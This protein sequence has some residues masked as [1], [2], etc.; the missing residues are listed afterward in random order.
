MLKVSFLKTL[1]AVLSCAF[2]WGI[3]SVIS[4]SFL[5]EGINE[6]YLVFLRLISIAVILFVYLTIARRDQL[7]KQ[8]LKEASI[9]GFFSVFLVSISFIYALQ[10]ISSG[11]VTLMISSA[12][13]FTVIWLKI[14]LKEERISSV[15]YFSVFI[16]FLGIAYL[17]LTQETG[18]ENQG[19]ILIGGSLAFLGVQCISLSTV[20]NRR[21]APK[22]KVTSWLAYQYPFVVV[23][24]TA[25]FFILG[26]EVQELN[27]SQIVRLTFLVF[28]NLGA[29]LTFTWLI[30][31]VSALQVASIDYLVPVVG[32]TSG[33][34]FLGESFNNNILVA[35]VFIF[36]SLIIN[37]YEE[38]SR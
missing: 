31:R 17:F 3:G 35:G 6:I 36:F 20:L 37:T 33:V 15:K 5:I 25:T 34:I 16:G 10:E 1:F 2:L 12:P 26:I 8:I 4:R 27:T 29:F 23:L 19:N 24:I 13:I 28:S 38:F 14:L 21:F 18:L 22:Y 30:Q 7:N 32:V 9:T 11:L